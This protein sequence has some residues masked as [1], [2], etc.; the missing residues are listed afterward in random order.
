MLVALGCNSGGAGGMDAGVDAGDSCDQLVADYAA[1]L[2]AARACTPGAPTQCQA[3]VATLPTICPNL[4]C[5][6][7]EF[8]N[9]G[10]AV[11][12]VRLKWLNSSCSPPHH[13]CPASAC[14]PAHPA[15]VCVSGGAGGPN[16]GTCVPAVRADSGT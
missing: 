5:D 12:A 4:A 16:A 13:N 6:G 8:V 2:A 9:G 14:V 10:T 3:L 15:S 1:A 7:Q 11:E